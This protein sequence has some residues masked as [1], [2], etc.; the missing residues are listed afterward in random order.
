MMPSFPPAVLSAGR[1]DGFFHPPAV[2]VEAL[3]TF[4]EPMNPDAW[5]GLPD[6]MP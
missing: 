6:D 2:P 5:T 1:H 3:P 4:H